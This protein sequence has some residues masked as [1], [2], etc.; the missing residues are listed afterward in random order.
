MV[1]EVELEVGPL[2][3]DLQEK[4]KNELRETPELVRTSTDELRAA[5]LK[6]KNLYWGDSDEVLLRYLR[7]VK[8]YPDSAL[9]LVS[10]FLNFSIFYLYH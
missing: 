8:F 5:L 9:A 4:A 10:D 6:E 1:N 7:P 3:P 2:T